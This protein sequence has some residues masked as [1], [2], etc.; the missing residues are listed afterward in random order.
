MA[1]P[2]RAVGGGQGLAE[3]VALGCQVSVGKKRPHDG[4]GEQSAREEDLSTVLCGERISASWMGGIRGVARGGRWEPGQGLCGS[5]RGG[6]AESGNIVGTACS[7]WHE[8][9]VARAISG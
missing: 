4:C 5:W 6:R 7:S 8:S 3:D 1:V 9:L 2:G